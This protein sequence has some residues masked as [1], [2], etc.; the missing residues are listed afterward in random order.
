[1]KCRFVVFILLTCTQ[2]VTSQYSRHIVQFRDKQ[3]SPYLVSAPAVYLS[4]ASINRRIRQHLTIDSTDLP[5]TPSYIDS[6]RSLAGVEVINQSKWLNQVLIRTTDSAALIRIRQFS[7][8]KNAMAIALKAKPGEEVIQEKFRETSTPLP[9]QSEISQ[10]QQSLRATDTLSYG[11]M[12]AQ[13]AIHNGH[14]LHNLN[15]TGRGMLI[16][17]LDG[18]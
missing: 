5:V 14:Y 12:Q 18:G 13:I 10:R 2:A 3:N 15:F 17:V 11:Y 8:V 7:F 16:A 9:D 6:L 4:Q 1:M